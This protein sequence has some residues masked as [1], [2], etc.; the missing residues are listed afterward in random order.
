MS[1]N[2]KKRFNNKPRGKVYYNKNKPP[3]PNVT[4][5]FTGPVTII[6]QSPPQLPPPMLPTNKPPWNFI[7]SAIFGILLIAAIL[8]IAIAIP[9]P[10]KSQLL[11]F[12]VLIVFAAGGVGA[13]LPG[14]INASLQ[15]IGYRATGA[16]AFALL[17]FLWNPADMTSTG[18]DCDNK[19]ML[20]ATVYLDGVP[21]PDIKVSFLTLGKD[22]TTDRY[23]V[24][25]LD[26]FE[27]E[28]VYACPIRFECE[29]LDTVIT[30]PKDLH[31]R[32]RFDF[33]SNKSASGKN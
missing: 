25:S 28:I 20:K 33:P 26:F 16:F 7:L 2:R 24:V 3:A 11:L 21:K 32:T 10:T 23:G 31:T 12:K 18:T 22:K 8:I 15:K 13:F 5:V 27:K 9:C 14:V 6:N 17:F 30:V 4:N 19:R 29:T 1:K